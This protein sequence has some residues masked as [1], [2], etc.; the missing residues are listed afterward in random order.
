[1]TAT[2]L[3]QAPAA[4]TG[5]R[6]VLLDVL[7]GVAVLGTLGT[8]IWI[9]T[10]PGGALG[11]LTRAIEA[12]FASV[13]SAVETGLRFLANG[14]FLGLLTILFGVGLE[15]QRASA[16]RR[17]QRWPGWYL[18]RASLLFLEG[19]L[20]F[21]LVFEFDILMGYAATAMIAAFLVART[22]A[23]RWM[24]GAAVT[25]LALVAA[26]TLALATADASDGEQGPSGIELYAEG[27]YLDQVLFRLRHILPLR[28]ETV[29]VIPLSVF[30]FLLGARLYRAGAFGADERGRLLRRRLLLVGACAFPL[31]AATAYSGNLTLVLV[32]RYLLPPLVALGYLGLAGLVLDHWHRLGW[33]SRR[34][35]AV[36]RMALSC[37]VLQ[38]ILA[39]AL[40]YGWGLGLAAIL[41][42]RR[43]WWTILAWAAISAL[44]LVV[45]DLWLRRFRQGPL[46]AAWRWAYQ[47]PQRRAR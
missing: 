17:G 27:S 44:L 24:I 35:A 28:L 19:L 26:G 30:L 10:D 40:C 21:V 37:Y 7:R 33:L 31:N 15:I 41:A 1:M 42:D 39:S 46:E 2:Q 47:L 4:R 13:A 29:F 9:F 3:G 5:D 36:G 20:H 38:N 25:H 16:R 43:P 45:S 32:D 23:G 14:K 22:T 18:W 6:I 34:L 11:F 12:P 8:N